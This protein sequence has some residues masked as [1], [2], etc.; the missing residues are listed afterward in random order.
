MNKQRVHKAVTEAEVESLFC[1]LD[2]ASQVFR[3]VN[4]DVVVVLF[5]P[6]LTGIL[7]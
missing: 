1:Q 6:L 2:L 4:I 3:V 5:L 7:K